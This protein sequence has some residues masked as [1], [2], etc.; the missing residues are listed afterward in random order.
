MAKRS[1]LIVAMLLLSALAK[2]DSFVNVAIQPQTFTGL[3]LSQTLCGSET[4]GATFLWDIPTNVFSNFDISASGVLDNSWSA[5]GGM[6]IGDGGIGVDITNKAG[7]NWLWS[8]RTDLRPPSSPDEVF[9]NA[10]GTYDLGLIEFHCAECQFVAG[11][12][13]SGE[14]AIVTAA[15]DGG[16]PFPHRNLPALFPCLLVS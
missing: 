5:V 15:S 3:C 16:A 11:A 14:T 2:A 8:A 1:E 13:I 10:P 12:F 7:D 9:S 6:T 4:L